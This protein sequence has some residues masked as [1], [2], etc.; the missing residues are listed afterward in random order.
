[1]VQNQDKYF[2]IGTVCYSLLHLQVRYIG[3]LLLG[4]L[5]SRF[6]ATS[7]E[8]WRAMHENGTLTTYLNQC[9]CLLNCPRE[10]R[11]RA[12]KYIML[13]NR[14]CHRVAE[15]KCVL[16]FYPLLICSAKFRLIFIY[17]YISPIFFL[18]VNVRRVVTVPPE[19]GVGFARLSHSVEVA[20]NGEAG[21]V[22]IFFKKMKIFN[23]SLA[24]T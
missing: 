17:I 9:N 22:I 6:P 21:Q 2:F 13:Q 8:C 16:I 4:V 11:L 5:R 23:R 18:Q 7:F 1:M 24:P 10:L 14:I 3:R 15:R 12:S 19:S 20:E